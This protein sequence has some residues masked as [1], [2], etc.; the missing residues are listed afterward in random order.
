MGSILVTPRCSVV[1]SHLLSRI[2]LMMKMMWLANWV[3]SGETMTCNWL[4]KN[5]S[6]T[7]LI[8]SNK[9]G[10]RAGCNSWDANSLTCRWIW[11]TNFSLW[12]TR[13]RSSW[14]TNWVTGQVSPPE[15]PE[16]MTDFRSKKKAVEVTAEGDFLWRQTPPKEHRNPVIFVHSLIWSSCS[17]SVDWWDV[18]LLLMVRWRESVIW[19]DSFVCLTRG[20]ETKSLVTVCQQL[21]QSSQAWL[22]P[23]V[24]C[25]IFL[26]RAIILFWRAA[27][28]GVKIV[29]EWASSW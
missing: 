11:V 24:K 18:R 12:Q 5:F 4:S 26:R 19:P 16:L 17:W 6:T 1:F 9:M 13:R 23:W 28:P 25:S 29:D 2:D 15:T 8:W 21:K 7:D 14:L 27:R 3:D 10:I 22:H 20:I